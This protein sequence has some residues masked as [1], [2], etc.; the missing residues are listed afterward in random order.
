VFIIFLGGSVLVFDYLFLV[1]FTFSAHNS[2][3]DSNFIVLFYNL[4]YYSPNIYIITRVY[5]TC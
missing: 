4:F 1:G 2:F 3:A 5:L